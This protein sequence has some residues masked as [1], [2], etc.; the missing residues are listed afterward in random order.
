MAPKKSTLK[1]LPTKG[2]NP[3]KAA[4]V[5]GGRKDKLATNHNQVLRTR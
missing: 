2:V 4:A 3:R 5:K 1:R